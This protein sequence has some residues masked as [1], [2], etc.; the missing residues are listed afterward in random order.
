MTTKYGYRL[1]TKDVS[2]WKKPPNFDNII[3][4]FI[5]KHLTSASVISGGEPRVEFTI[6]EL[7]AFYS[8][9]TNNLQIPKSIFE[10]L[11][12]YFNIKE[13]E[14][15]DTT[16]NNKINITEEQFKSIIINNIIPFRI[17]FSYD[18]NNKIQQLE[19]EH[20]H[21]LNLNMTEGWDELR[22][23]YKNS[24][25]IIPNIF[26]INK[27]AK[28]ITLTLYKNDGRDTQLT[29]TIHEIPTVSRGGSLKHK[30]TRRTRRPKRT[31][32]PKRTRPPKRTRRPK[33]PKRTR[34]T[35]KR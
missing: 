1:S 15:T 25:D 17:P 22:N 4:Q 30:M 8:Q 13:G 12:H 5:I 7:E 2:D 27:S 26:G 33:R 10:S 14:G 28:E 35:K 11:K 3:Q 9:Q 29:Y 18:I 6:N 31:N 21:T 23:L 32:R 24:S 16:N 19:K 34:R 20:F